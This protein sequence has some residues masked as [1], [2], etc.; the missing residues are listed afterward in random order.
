MKLRDLRQQ[1]IEHIK[2]ISDEQFELEL[3]DAGIEN[4]QPTVRLNRE[5]IITPEIQYKDT[6]W[7][8]LFYGKTSDNPI[9]VTTDREVA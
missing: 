5:L 7:G 6:K 2:S 3:R 1:F 9:V 8:T 4:Q